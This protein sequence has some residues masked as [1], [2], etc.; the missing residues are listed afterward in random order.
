MAADVFCIALSCCFL[1]SS[2]RHEQSLGSRQS[3][4]YEIPHLLWNPDSIPLAHHWFPYTSVYILPFLKSHVYL[5]PETGIIFADILSR[6]N[7]QGSVHRKYIPL[8]IFPTRCKITQFIYFW[9]S[10]LHVSGGISTNHQEH[11]QLYLQYLVHVNRYYYLPLLWGSWS[12]SQLVPAPTHAV[13][14]RFLF[15]YSVK[16][17]VS[18]LAIGRITSSLSR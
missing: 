13:F 15:L 5:G 4:T 10:A 14:S 7:V 6:F 8:D 12:W 11:I 16:E 2:N 17:R 9:K 3:H 18:I 1:F